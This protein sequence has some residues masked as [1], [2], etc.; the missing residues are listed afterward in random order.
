MQREY[1]QQTLKKLQTVE[2]G[3]FKDFQKICDKH[4]LS[5]F[6]IGGTAIGAVRHKGFIPWDDDIDVGMLREDYEKFLRI[7][8]DELGSSY[9]LLTM[10]S[11]QGYVLALAKISKKGTVFL[12]ATDENRTYESGIFL[13]II[14]YDV[15]CADAKKRAQQIKKAWFWARMCV[16]SEYGQVKLPDS[17]VGIRRTAALSVAKLVHGALKLFRV[18]K[19]SLYRRFLKAARMYEGKESIYYADLSCMDPEASIIE[20]NDIFPLVD[21]PFEDGVMRMLHHYDNY[22]T[23]QFGDYMT[24]PPEDQRKNHYPAIL[25]FG[26]K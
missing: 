11:K 10:E 26:E 18:K 19:L 6:A 2:L 4:G 25:D 7:A 8:P 5:Y 14:P 16:M 15:V 9:D 20:S 17:L 3:I 13:D 21:F 12:E 23:L 22:L 1:D 24:L